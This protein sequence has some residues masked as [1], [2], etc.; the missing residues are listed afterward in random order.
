MLSA[1]ERHQPSVT[2]AVA[3]SKLPHIMPD[4]EPNSKSSPSAM[5]SKPTDQSTVQHIWIVTG[6]AGCGKSTV[7]NGLSNE[8]GVSFLEGDDYHNKSN[9]D[10]MGNG[11]PLTDEDR[12]DWLI[13]LRKAAIDALSPSESNNFHRPA[14]VVVACSALKQK[15]RDVMRVAAYGSPSVQ[16]H[17]IYLKLTEEVLM[18]RVSQRQAHYMKSDMVRSQLQALEEPKGEWDAITINVEGS[19]DQVQQRVFDAVHKKLE[20]NQ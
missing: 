15:Y 5:L 18:Q 6:P 9:K 14:G 7:G 1:G 10:K 17:F 13:S 3:S 20:E 12:W 4:L 11:I 19:Q 8:L 2:P 16:I